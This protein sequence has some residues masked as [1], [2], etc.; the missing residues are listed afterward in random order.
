[1]LT[2]THCHLASR[3]FAGDLE[4]VL[5]RA[6]L[7]GVSRFVAIGTD[8]ED[9]AAVLKL[10]GRHP[11]SVFATVGIHPGSV[12]EIDHE[13]GWLDRIAR[14]AAEP[15]VCAIG[16]IGLDFYHPPPQ[17]W[18]PE[19][20]RTVQREVFRLQLELA[21]N[22]GFNVV[23]H[24]RNSWDE[25]HALVREFDGRLRAVFHCFT[26]TADE[27]DALLEAGHLVSFTGIATFKNNAGLLAVAGARPAGSFMVETD[28]PY[29]APEPYRGKR[30]EPAYLRETAEAV[31]AARNQTLEQTAEETTRTA[32]AFFR[33]E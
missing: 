16:E 10:A 21:A 11:G 23:V 4:A 33:F 26:G 12:T 17:G 32:E 5:E 3:K 1:M 29:L 20:H 6:A 24:Q 19:D 30:C 8:L 2:D 13:S 27:A 18:S 7:R 31:A 22:R 28:S 25:T 14:L 15:G 9:G